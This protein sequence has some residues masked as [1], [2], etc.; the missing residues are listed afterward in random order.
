MSVSRRIHTHS[1]RL[2]NGDEALVTRVLAEDG[3]IGYG[4]TLTLDA[5]ACRHMAESN[6]GLRKEGTIP[7]P[8]EIQS[9]IGSIPWPEERT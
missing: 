2:A 9:A 4:F 3:R 5:T 6:A 7:L 1:V 8:P